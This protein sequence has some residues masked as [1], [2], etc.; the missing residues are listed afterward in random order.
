MLKIRNYFP[1]IIKFIL[2]KLIVDSKLREILANALDIEPEELDDNASQKNISEWDSFALMAM[3]AALEEEFKIERINLTKWQIIDI[4][5]ALRK[6]KTFKILSLVQNNIGN[7][8]IMLERGPLDK[9][10]NDGQLSAFKHDGF[11]Q[12]M[13]T[14]RDRNNLE[15]LWSKN[16]APWKTWK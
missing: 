12:P 3:V 6:N 16:L 9:V 1:I 14:L 8:N 5:N 7:E 10:S 13:D 2:I 11:W 15:D 4:A